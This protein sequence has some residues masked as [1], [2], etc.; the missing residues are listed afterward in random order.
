MTHQSIPHGSRFRHAWPDVTL[1]NFETAKILVKV[2]NQFQRIA[3]SQVGER[4]GRAFK[5]FIIATWREIFSGSRHREQL[6]QDFVG[7]QGKPELRRR[8]HDTSRTPLK[9]GLE[10]FLLQNGLCTMPE[11]GVAGLALSRF[12]LEA[13]L[14][15]I[16]RCGEVGCWHTRNCACS[17]KFKNTKLFRRGF[18]ENVGLEVRVCG[19]VNGGERN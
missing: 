6:L 4:S 2:E 9:E 11:R 16:A 12:D 3:R 8:P 13:S 5:C 15:D 18:S 19:E 10:T 7:G 1:R 17:Q 14:D